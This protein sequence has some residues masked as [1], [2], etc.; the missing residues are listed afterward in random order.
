MLRGSGLLPA[1]VRV[2]YSTALDGFTTSDVFWPVYVPV[3]SHIV[4]GDTVVVNL[5]NP[6]NPFFILDVELA[7][8]YVRS[9][10]FDP[11]DSRAICEWGVAER[12]AMGLCLENVPATFQSRYVVPISRQTSIAPPYAWAWH[13]P[14]NYANNPSSPLGKVR[15]DRLF[16]GTGELRNDWRLEFR[17]RHWRKPTQWRG[18]RDRESKSRD[19]R[20]GR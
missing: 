18:S 11:A 17:V 4:L 3:Q 8:E 1:F 6:Y 5:P 10:S 14:N 16:V 15:M 19:Q 2:E 20:S 7:A 9:R 13:L 12:S